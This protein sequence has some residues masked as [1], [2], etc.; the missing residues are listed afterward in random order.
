MSKKFKSFHSMDEDII[1]VKVLRK[2]FLGFVLGRLC[3]CLEW[4][5]LVKRFS[6][7]ILNLKYIPCWK[8]MLPTCVTNFI[9]LEVWTYH[10]SPTLLRGALKLPMHCKFAIFFMISCVFEFRWVF[11][12]HESTLIHLW[13]IIFFVGHDF[14]Y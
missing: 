10:K 7:C 14:K 3:T 5:S 4:L 6:P 13:K 12:R 1:I 9:T 8:A 2:S 11:Y